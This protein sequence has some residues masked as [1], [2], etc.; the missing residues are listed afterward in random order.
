MED[1][2]HCALQERNYMLA[3]A[4]SDVDDPRMFENIRNR[5]NQEDIYVSYLRGAQQ[6]YHYDGNFNNTRFWHQKTN[7]LPEDENA[8]VGFQEVSHYGGF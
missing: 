6:K 4:I 2:R 3:K 1:V 8:L 5:Y 7:R